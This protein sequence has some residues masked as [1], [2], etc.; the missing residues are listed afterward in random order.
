MADIKK[1]IKNPDLEQMDWL[2]VKLYLRETKDFWWLN[3]IEANGKKITQ[4]EIALEKGRSFTKEE[5]LAPNK[6]LTTENYQT[7][8]R[9]VVEIIQNFKDEHKKLEGDTDQAFEELKKEL[10]QINES[11]TNLG[12]HRKPHTAFAAYKKKLGGKP[13]DAWSELKEYAK[14]SKGEIEINLPGYGLIY[15]KLNKDIKIGDL[16]Y[17]E[18]AFSNSTDGFPIT[19]K[20]FDRAWESIKDQKT[21]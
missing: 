8:L 7:Y 14:I 1:E 12:G 4:L 2:K 5:L 13:G 9:R 18:T 10:E 19:R 20:A 17:K 3:E 6:W 15:L 16:R 21:P 11:D